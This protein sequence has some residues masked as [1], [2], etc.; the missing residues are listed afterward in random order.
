MARTK[1]T[2]QIGAIEGE[3]MPPTPKRINLSDLASIRREM[4]AVYRQVRGGSLDAA[5]GRGLIWML[6]QIGTVTKDALMES[7]MAEIE[8]ALSGE[9]SSTVVEQLGYMEEDEDE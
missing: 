2:A 7:R 3:L 6:S 5:E 1:K 9:Q 4:N 8:M